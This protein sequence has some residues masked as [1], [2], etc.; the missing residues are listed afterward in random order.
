MDDIVSN[1]PFSI[2][3]LA[4]DISPIDVLSHM[5]VLC[6]EA[7]IPYIYVPSKAELG[8]AAATK[9]ATSCILVTPPK[10]TAEYK[11]YYEFAIKEMSA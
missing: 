8:M 9:R 4:G 2:V 3:V 6:E 5:P 11:E 1:F 10:S 7:K